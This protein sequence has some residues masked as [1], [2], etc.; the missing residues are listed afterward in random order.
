MLN[1]CGGPTIAPLVD[2]R[3]GFE[4]GIRWFFEFIHAH[5]QSCAIF[6]CVRHNVFPGAAAGVLGGVRA[7]PGDV[8]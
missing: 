2:H 6:P 5:T 7:D 8:V 3:Q 1:L 4:S